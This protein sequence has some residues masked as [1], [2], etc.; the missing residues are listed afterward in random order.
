MIVSLRKVS[1]AVL[2]LAWTAAPALAAEVHSFAASATVSRSSFLKEAFNAASMPLGKTTEDLLL[3]GKERRIFSASFGAV[4]LRRSVTRGEAIRVVGS[5]IGNQT[6]MNDVALTALRDVPALSS[7]VSWL[8]IALGKQWLAPVSA[9]YFGWDRPLAGTDAD[10]LLQV[11]RDGVTAAE[12]SVQAVQT[13]T[14]IR[15]SFKRLPK[16]TVSSPGTVSQK[17]VT[18]LDTDLIR[19]VWKVLNTDYHYQD[20][21]QSQEATYKALEAAI[22]SLGDQHTKFL[23]PEQAQLFQTQIEG[24]I[25]G[26]GAQV[27]ER[28]KKIIVVAP[29]A[30]S[31]A[32]KA[33][34]LAGDVITAVDGKSLEGVDLVKAIG[35]IRGEKGT[36]VKLTLDRSGVTLELTVMRDKVTVPEVEISWQGN[37]AV[38]GL[39][40]FGRLTDESL[41][42][43][44]EEIVAKKPAGIILD[45]RND[46]GGLLDAAET[47]LSN[48]LPKNTVVAQIRSRDG[49]RLEKTK[50]E[51]T[52]SASTPLI[53]L[54]NKGS[55]SASEIVAGALQD[56]KRATV[57]GETTYGKGTV[58]NVVSFSDGSSLKLTIAEWLTPKGRPID[59]KGVEPDIAVTATTERDVY[60]LKALDLL[61]K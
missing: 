23:R 4:E 53:V 36:Y 26:I 59:G 22:D 55:A 18:E 43:L 15:I 25:I 24:E 35:M 17:S 58:Q 27:E 31:P 48:F 50:Y 42:G 56:H 7:D 5:L 9:N 12:K 6:P 38:V 19:S 8:Q 29:I 21:I 51:P 60:M 13:P 52:V 20:K 32:E 39:R 57:V 34:V 14:N 49:T 1:V 2:F 16:G 45:L 10:R 44:M 54:V 28:D 37:V 30:G 46:P 11:I 40:Q 33:G 3:F 61:R 41:R 47:V